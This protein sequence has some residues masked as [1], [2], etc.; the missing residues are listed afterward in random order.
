MSHP[1]TVYIG[2][3]ISLLIG[4]PE[5]YLPDIC[6]R[7][8]SSWTC[9][10][11]ASGPLYRTLHIGPNRTGPDSRLPHPASSPFTAQQPGGSPPPTSPSAATS[12][13]RETLSLP[14]PPHP[15]VCLP[16]P[17]FSTALRCAARHLLP[18]VSAVDDSLQA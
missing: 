9:G 12:T 2:E 10:D 3:E 13:G 16:S 5:T 14:S 7:T 8:V 1:T 6:F 17:A 11:W 15:P 4:P 18:I